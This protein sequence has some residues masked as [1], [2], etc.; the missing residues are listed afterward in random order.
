MVTKKKL[1][2]EIYG[3]I[4]MIF[5]LSLLV[6]LSA[7]YFLTEFILRSPSGL[8]QIAFKEDLL[9]MILMAVFIRGIMH[10]V[11][12]IGIA[13][14]KSWA[15]NWIF[16]GWPLLLII[17]Y[18]LIYLI[19]QEW[20]KEGYSSGFA[21]LISWPKVFLFFVFVL[22]EF[23]YVAKEL[24][25]LD[26]EIENSTESLSRMETKKISVV[27]FSAIIFFVLLM[28]LG[29]PLTQGFHKGFYKTRGVRSG[30]SLALQQAQT[31]GIIIADEYS[32]ATLKKDKELALRT[33]T[34]LAEE[35]EEAADSPEI[36]APKVVNEK[37]LEKKELPYVELMGY[38]ASFCVI[39]G[40]IFQVMEINQSQNTAGISSAAYTLF[41][42]GFLLLAIFSLVTKLPALTLMGIVSAILCGYILII[43][44]KFG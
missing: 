16:I 23:I 15:R 2:F 5:G 32:K 22:F 36:T 1:F 3:L 43:K 10:V 21:S 33:K 26:S 37:S 24:R 14:I 27:F 17:N 19:S 40:L 18:G 35:V 6:G 20:I 13:R 25:A 9:I 28:Y 44:T 29:K 39:L 42:F 34:I 41:A 4:R 30:K 11:I 7:G 12:G 31:E 8:N 38:V